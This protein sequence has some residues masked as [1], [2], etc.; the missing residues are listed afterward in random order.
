[1]VWHYVPPHEL[2]PGPVTLQAGQPLFFELVDRVSENIAPSG[3][4][5]N[6]VFGERPWNMYVIGEIR[7]QDRT[8]IIRHLGFCRE[9]HKDIRFRAVNDDEFEYED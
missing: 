3:T 6:P 8:G 5:I 7:Y 9:M 2:A 1:M 4:L